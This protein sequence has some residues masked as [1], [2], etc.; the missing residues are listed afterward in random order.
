MKTSD[1]PSVKVQAHSRFMKLIFFIMVFSVGKYAVVLREIGQ[2]AK[3]LPD[4]MKI[5][6]EV[7]ALASALVVLF[8]RFV[9]IAGVLVP[10]TPIPIV[11]RL[12][13]LRAYFILC[14]VFAETVA[15]YGFVLGSMGS[16]LVDAAPF[17][18]G[19]LLLFALCYPRLPS[20]L[21]DRQA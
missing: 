6:L 16:S 14:Y 21:E 8:V 7:W 9:K 20:D 4:G 17:F 10:D 11:E 1:P 19:S 15:L 12:A 3:P 2:S 5:G 18:V 13:K